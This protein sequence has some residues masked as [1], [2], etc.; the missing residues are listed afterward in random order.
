METLQ[1][2]LT[3]L[4]IVAAIVWLI[5]KNIKKKPQRK[6]KSICDDCT[7]CALKDK[8]ENAKTSKENCTI[9]MK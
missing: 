9:Q 3:A 2:I 1:Y 8:I 4:T 5:Y 6:N 7:G